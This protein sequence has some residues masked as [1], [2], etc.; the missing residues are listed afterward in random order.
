VGDLGDG[1]DLLFGVEFGEEAGGDLEAV[2]EVSGALGVEVVG[3]DALE[4]LGEGELDGGAVFELRQSEGGAATAAGGGVRDGA[5]GG[6]VEVA[7]VFV[8]E[9]VAE[10][11]VAVGEDV[12]ALH[13]GVLG[14]VWHGGT[15]LGDVA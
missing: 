1:L 13:G 7:E 12:A 5:A 14:G 6:V 8:A 3:G 15:L 4:D 9:A 10:A 11:A 2:E